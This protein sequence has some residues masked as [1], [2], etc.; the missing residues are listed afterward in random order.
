MSTATQPSRILSPLL[1]WYAAHA[2]D[3]PWRQPGATPWGVLVSE[4]MLQQTPVARVEPV[5]REWLARWPEPADLAAEAP[6]E[7]VRAWGRLGY[8]RRALRLHACAVALTAEHG[9]QVPDDLGALLALPGIGQYTAA[10]VGA[11]AFGLRAAVVDTNVR[12]VQ[13]RAVSGVALPA[14]T[15]TAA[16]LRLAEQ[17][18]PADPATAARWS[19]AVME[20]GALVCTARSPGCAD[21]PLRDR[22]AW[23]A[24]GSPPYDGPPRRVQAWAGT[25]RQCRGVIVGRLRE[26]ADAV[27]VADLRA[28]WPD[29]AQFARSLDGLLSDGLAEWDGDD[30]VR[31]PTG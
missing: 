20:L 26:S 9:G 25:D 5:W 13:A 14:P 29:A 3:L 12:R 17:L 28:A 1:D 4:V 22:C 19:V 16:E 6:G 23:V 10:A 27:P 24:A 8:P 2:R 11:F 21:C 31:L 30:R 7:A 15:L 18:L